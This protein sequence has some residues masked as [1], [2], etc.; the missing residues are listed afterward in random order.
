MS[1]WERFNLM[2]RSSSFR[3]ISILVL[4][5]LLVEALFN[6]ILPGQAQENAT[7][8][9]QATASAM[10]ISGDDSD[11]LPMM[12]KLSGR[13]QEISTKAIRINDMVVL[14]PLGFVL[15]GSIRVGTVITIRA[16]LRNDDTLIIISLII[17]LETPTAT[18]T[19]AATVEPTDEPTAQPT[20]TATRLATQVATLLPTM[21]A[22]LPVTVIVIPGCDKP[23][24]Q[25]ALL[26]SSTFDVPY[27]EVVA[28]RC[29]GFSFGVI[30]RAYLLVV[31][32]EGQ[33]NPVSVILILNL[34]LQG[35]RWSII[36]IE[37]GVRPEPDS[38][39][40]IISQSGTV[41]VPNCRLLKK[42][43]KKLYEQYCKK[44]KKPK[45]SKR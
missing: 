39:I 14:L 33:G 28:W 4:G 15:P 16:N 21:V 29:K 6:S 10:P 31:S 13:V 3:W 17:G 7:P 23:R 44:P 27:A 25:L 42:W 40:I 20:P 22:T 11:E 35:K 8:T 12:V 37:V 9:P 30:A 24:Q 19:D 36:I 38:L 32:G 34:R 26:V 2:K 45:K 43:N 18:P 41:V 5:A 1:Y